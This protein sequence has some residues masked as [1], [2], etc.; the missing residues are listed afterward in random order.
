MYLKSYAKLNLAINVN[1]VREDGYHDLDMIMVPLKLFDFIEMERLNYK[2]TYVVCD[3][4]DLEIGR[5]N[6]VTHTINKLREKYNFPTNYLVTIHKEIPIKAGLGGGSSNAATVLKAVI[7]DNKIK[8]DQ[9]D[10]VDLSK[11]IGADVPY[12]LYNTPARVRGIGEIVDPIK[13]KCKYHVLLVKPS[14][15]LDTKLVFAECDRHERNNTDIEALIEALRTGND[16]EIAKLMKNALE[17]AAISMLPEI[18][19]IKDSLHNDG[20]NMVMMSGSGSCVFALS[21]SRFKL[22]KL[23][24]KYK[25]MGYEVILTQLL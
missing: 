14:E 12:F 20:L 15:G 1:G 9:Q 13:V 8:A 4:L 19:K 24:N 25:K 3:E 2:D 6:L 10:L 7:K 5:Y 11:S 17:D 21:R 22:L 23:Y 16:N 18:K